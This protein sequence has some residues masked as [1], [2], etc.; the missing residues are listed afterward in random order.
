MY[1]ANRNHIYQKWKDP[2]GQITGT[3]ITTGYGEE[4]GKT[5]FWGNRIPIIKEVNPDVWQ[6]IQTFFLHETWSR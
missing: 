4:R 1:P 3:N 5:E 2:L 6:K